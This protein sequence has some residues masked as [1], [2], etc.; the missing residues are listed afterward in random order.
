M[1]VQRHVLFSILLAIL[2]G[3]G[4][5]G[6]GSSGFDPSFSESVLIEQAIDE[7]RC[8]PGDGALTIC[9]SGATV[10]NQAGG[11]PSPSDVRV[12]ANVER[13]DFVDCGGAGDVAACSVTVGVE[14]EGVPPDAEIRIA[15]RLLPDGR[16]SVGGPLEVAAS[17]DGP[18]M[19]APVTVELA[20]GA[21][22]ARSV[23]VAVLV[24]RSPPADVAAEVDEL[25]ETGASYAFVLAPVPITSAPSP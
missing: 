24:F 5:G 1:P 17:N 25:R 7:Q 23:Q 21:G 3:C 2:V 4:C 11:V 9:P 13:A 16:W 6:S 19:L 22:A 10:P 12:S 14:A 18:S 15:S 8:V 20:D